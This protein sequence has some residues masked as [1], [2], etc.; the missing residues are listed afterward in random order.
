LTSPEEASHRAS[1]F[2]LPGEVQKLGGDVT[3]SW[4]LPGVLAGRAV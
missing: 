1:D 3:S 4:L 2:T